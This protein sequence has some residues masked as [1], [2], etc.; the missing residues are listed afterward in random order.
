M[1]IFEDVLLFF[2]G[3][4]HIAELPM[5]FLVPFLWVLGEAANARRFDH[6]LGYAAKD[7]SV[8]FMDFIPWAMRMRETQR[9]QVRNQHGFG[10]DPVGVG[11][12]WQVC[13]ENDVGS[14]QKP[15][16]MGGL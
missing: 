10:K 5:A 14:W 4:C 2:C 15:G 11:M 16:K 7:A 6:E 13:G 1:K 9:E 8:S 3:K 12:V